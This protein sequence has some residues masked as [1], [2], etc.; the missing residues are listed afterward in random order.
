VTTLAIL[1]VLAVAL[2]RYSSRDLRR[3]LDAIERWHACE[4]E[5]AAHDL[6]RDA[7]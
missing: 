4:L 7:A 3:R 5:A 6:T 2:L 1:A